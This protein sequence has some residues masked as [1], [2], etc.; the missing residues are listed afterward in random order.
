MKNQADKMGDELA[1]LG[2]K[3]QTAPV[4]V[5]VSIRSVKKNDIWVRHV[6]PA[7]LKPWRRRKLG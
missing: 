3:L 4:G 7:F 1:G 6:H 5:R 2:S